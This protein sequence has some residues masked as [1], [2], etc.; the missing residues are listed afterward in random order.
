MVYRIDAGD[1]I[2]A[3][4]L[5]R[6]PLGRIAA[7]E[8]GTLRAPQLLRARFR[9]R[10]PLV[11]QIDARDTATGLLCDSQRRP[12]RSACHIE[13]V[14]GSRQPQPRNEQV[15]LFGGQPARLTDVAAERL[16]TDVR[17]E[18]AREVSIADA[19]EIDSAAGRHRPS[20]GPLRTA[21]RGYSVFITFGALARF[22]VRDEH[23]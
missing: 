3:A 14:T 5:E 15:L 20:P 1:G 18:R 16:A 9:A 22:G 11:V 7:I 21:S 12:A 2:E 23:R 13:Q 8:I 17:V 6:Q 19:V 10:D 4:I